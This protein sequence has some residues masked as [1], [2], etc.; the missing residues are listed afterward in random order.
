[1]TGTAT[2]PDGSDDGEDDV[3]GMDAEPALAIDRDAHDLG[4]AL[5]ETLGGQDV[6][7]LGGA[8]AGGQTTEGAV[9]CGVRVAAHE[10]E[11]GLGEALL[12]PDDV[13]DALADVGWTK[14]GDTV[15]LRVVL[16]SLHHG[17][18]GRIGD[19]GGA[20]CGRHVVVSRR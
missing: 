14:V 9:G 16:K 18:Y 6:L 7:D 2:R 5:P 20:A 17:S 1:V 15:P 11:S 4:M 3:L 12:G 19:A 8:D 13:H 10:E